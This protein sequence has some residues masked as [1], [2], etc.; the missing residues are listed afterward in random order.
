M[1]LP[2]LVHHIDK[3]LGFNLNHI[4]RTS[5]SIFP[6]PSKVQ[7][8]IDKVS[9]I[10]AWESNTHLTGIPPHVKGLIDLHALKVEL[11]QLA[12]TIY[13]KVMSGMT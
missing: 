2:S 3:V 4:A 6:D 10:H 12:G 13:E 7:P 8:V 9:V 11:A 1:G 5:I